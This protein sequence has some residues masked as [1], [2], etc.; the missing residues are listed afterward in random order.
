MTRL[1][2]AEAAGERYFRLYCKH[3]TQPDVD[4]LFN[5]LEGMHS[6]ND[7]LG[8]QTGGKVFVDQ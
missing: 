2:T 3:V 1:T 8:K 7:R 5:L 6:L 4:T